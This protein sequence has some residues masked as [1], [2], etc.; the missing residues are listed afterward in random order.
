MHVILHATRVRV[1]KTAITEQALSTQWRISHSSVAQIMIVQPLSSQL[2]PEFAPKLTDQ[3]E[4]KTTIPITRK[5][6]FIA[7]LQHATVFP[8]SG[9]HVTT[10]VTCLKLPKKPRRQSTIH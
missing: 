8:G 9:S 10:R 3:I 1:G 7:C 6:D 2:A 4:E 5:K